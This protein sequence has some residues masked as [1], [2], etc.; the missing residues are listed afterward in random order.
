MSQGDGFKSRVDSHPVMVIAGA[1]AVLSGIVGFGYDRIR[2][3]YDARVAQQDSQ[4]V[5]AGIAY[6]A[7][8]LAYEATVQ[9]Q[10]AVI[11]SIAR[12]VAGAA[13]PIEIEKILIDES[14]AAER[15]GITYFS[16]DRFFAL[17][18]DEPSDWTYEETT[19]LENVASLT[20]FTEAEVVDAFVQ[21]ANAGGCARDR[22]QMRRLLTVSP[23]HRWA[24][25]ENVPV[26]G[27]PGLTTLAPFVLVQR[28]PHDLVPE[29]LC[30]DLPVGT[31][32]ATQATPTS[33]FQVLEQFYKGESTGLML[34]LQLNTEVISGSQA[35][36][37]LT[38]IEKKG[39]V[40]YVGLNTTLVDVTVDGQDYA[41]YQVSRELILI[42]TTN[43]IYLI[44]TFVPTPNFSRTD[45]EWV[46]RWLKEFRIVAAP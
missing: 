7:T 28:F 33:Q 3:D 19:E 14:E 37:S 41:E 4:A 35:R 34:L 20:G 6:E 23:V 10:S 21:V 32:A 27:V 40:V 26:E 30:A 11:G 38:S 1:L 2:D 25:G 39:N 13:A 36:T 46:S 24:K 22:D 8:V 42:S 18:E 43:D 17:A 5:A 44:K 15:P 29:M 16:A 9:A 12:G 45:Q 31:P